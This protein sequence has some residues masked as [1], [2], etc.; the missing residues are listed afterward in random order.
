MPGTTPS[1]LRAILGDWLLGELVGLPSAS[2]ATINLTKLP[3][4]V[5]GRIELVGQVVWCLLAAYDGEGIR[6][7]FGRRRPDLKGQC[8]AE[9]LGVD[10][11]ADSPAAQRVLELARE[12]SPAG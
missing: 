2:V 10:W 4:A 12:L 1:E 8:P 6:R 9:Y 5:A 3:P 7:W 11:L